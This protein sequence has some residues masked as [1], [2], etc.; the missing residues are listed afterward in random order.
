MLTEENEILKKRLR[1]VETIAQSGNLERAKFMEGASWIA[2]KAVQEGNNFSTKLINLANEYDQR[3]AACVTD[4]GINEVDGV[5]FL[6]VKS[7]VESCIAQEGKD[8]KS[9][10]DGLLENVNYHLSEATKQ[11]GSGGV[12]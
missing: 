2:R 3:A 4:P 1:A 12:N 7:W 6:R 8:I 5:E 11:F 9:R 10:F